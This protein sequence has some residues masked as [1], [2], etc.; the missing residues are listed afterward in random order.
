MHTH[1]LV[2]TCTH[3]HTHTLISKLLYTGSVLPHLV[4]C[5]CTYVMFVQQLRSF[6]CYVQSLVHIK[7]GH[8]LQIL[9]RAR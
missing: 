8:V 6:C 3:T 5:I 1:V 7:L 4:L 9:F 2:H